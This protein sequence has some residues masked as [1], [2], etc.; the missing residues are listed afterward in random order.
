MKLG[1]DHE[2]RLNGELALYLYAYLSAV[3]RRLAIMR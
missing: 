3:T 2:E 1:R